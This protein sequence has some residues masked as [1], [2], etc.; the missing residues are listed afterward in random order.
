MSCAMPAARPSVRSS[1]CASPRV[2]ANIAQVSV[3]HGARGE[4]RS[5]FVEQPPAHRR[6]RLLCLPL[7][8]GRLLRRG[9]PADGCVRH[10]VECA[11]HGRLRDGRTEPAT[12]GRRMNE[13]RNRWIKLSHARTTLLHR[14]GRRSRSLPAPGTGLRT[15]RIFPAAEGAACRASGCQL[16]KHPSS[17]FLRARAAPECSRA[18]WAACCCGSGSEERAAGTPGVARRSCEGA[19]TRMCSPLRCTAPRAGR[20]CAPTLV[21]HAHA[22]LSRSERG[23]ACART[24]PCMRG[25]HFARRTRKAACAARRV[26]GAQLRR[27]P[28]RAHSVQ[29]CGARKPGYCRRR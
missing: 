3:V 25:G 9:A 17:C 13:R 15:K 12:S 14:Q 19:P 10:K 29:R 26:A 27:A 8:A 5:I 18:A 28:S 6:K 20:S 4:D 23:A 22:S 21:T 7:P 11:R 16:T 1:S 2:V 24:L